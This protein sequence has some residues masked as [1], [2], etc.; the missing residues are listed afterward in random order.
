M[1]T[2]QD[3]EHKLSVKKDGDVNFVL[4]LVTHRRSCVLFVLVNV[5]S[6]IYL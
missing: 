5:K 3:Y 1:A 2:L 4:E 6:F